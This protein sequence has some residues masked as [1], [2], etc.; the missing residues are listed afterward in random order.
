MR[1]RTLTRRF[2]LVLAGVTGIL[3]VL[4][5]ASLV[6]VR[7][8]DE[9]KLLENNA[10]MFAQ[11][12]NDQICQGYRVYY[13]SGSYKFLEIVRSTMELNQDVQRILV[14][15]VSGEVLYDSLESIDYNLELDRPVRR[16]EDRRLIEASAKL[17][18]RVFHASD[19]HL[20]PILM[21]V[22]PY[23]E[24]WG[25]HESSVL[26]VFNYRSLIH[27]MKALAL[28]FTGL[29]LGS[30]AVMALVARRLA[31]RIARPIEAAIVESSRDAVIG[32][33]LS[34]EITSWNKGAESIYGYSAGE[35]L[36]KKIDL[37]ISSE[38]AGTNPGTLEKLKR[39]EVLESYE[40]EGLRKD[41][42][43][44]VVSL[45]MSR[46]LGP[47]GKVIGASTIARDITDQKRAE[48]GQA[49]LY[50]IAEI[51]N[52]A[53]DLDSFYA[54]LHRVI[55]ELMYAQNFFIALSD[56][57]TGEIRFPYFVD[58]FDSPPPPLKPGQGLTGHIISTGRPLLL[59]EDEIGELDAGGKIVSRGAT[60]VDWLGVPLRTGDRTFGV[61]AV[62][63]Y[64]ERIRYGEREKDLLV[65]VSQH[66]AA[67]IEKKRAEKQI[68]R[69]AFQDALTGLANRIRLEDRLNVALASARRERHPLA[70][71]F[72][73]LDRFKVIN[74]SLGHRV[75]DLLLKEVA[76][77]LSGMVRESDTLSRLG[78]DEFLVLL[79]KLD[80]S[81]NA[82]S[83]ARKIQQ[84]F[85]KPFQVADREMFV[86]IS[87]GISIFPVDGEDADTL[88][89]HADAAMYAAKQRGRDNFQ[90]YSHDADPGGVDRLALETQLH[91]AIERSE[92]KVYFQPVVRLRD[93]EVI[94]AEALVRWQHP[95]R[96]LLLPDDFVSLAEDSGLILELGTFVLQEAC[97]ETVSWRNKWGRDLSVSV[98]LS[99]RQLQERGFV[100]NV[101]R[102]L[103]DTGLPA[104]A[105]S[106]EVT[107]SVA[108]QNLDVSLVMLRELR[109]LGI[110]ITMDDFGTGYS[111]LNYLKMLP[112]NTVKIDRSFI[113]D[114]ATDPN[115]AS[116]VRASIVMAHELRLRV[117]A[118]GVETAEQLRFLCENQCDDLQ[119]FLYSPA[120]T[121]E[122]LDLLLESNK[123]LPT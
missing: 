102:I 111:S 99:V 46:I 101:R 76:D 83:V 22:S 80:R 38:R 50:R 40:T 59:T 12:T 94:G 57:A 60:A 64:T 123:R 27:T 62:Q 17:H 117:V 7:Y 70:V 63:S 82:G 84:S 2:E 19:P 119:G 58:E 61:L 37:L 35:V 1:P 93:G 43:K 77:R 87:T 34:G 15:S 109:S 39:G 42:T 116:I 104:E 121:S 110:G 89:K 115:D 56:E 97:R 11:T 71:L 54:E 75:G 69:L 25:R 112:V 14:L 96:G 45:T 74:D 92:F 20:G 18:F 9:K 48:R 105:L 90:Y 88:V 24:E 108:M 5:A 120:I 118:E 106:L 47:G 98:N 86:T 122:E 33:S 8:R 78:G 114:V 49:A 100:A 66:I 107:E 6:F 67:A 26:Y 21:I 81:E 10:L 36:G 51:T 4:V 23:V 28:P 52:A 16:L 3:L 55:S 30:L 41:G 44:I 68:E 29:M 31:A 95:E 32:E 65:F 91:R 13:D 85:R 113:R 79:S 53:E 103:E 72:I 73:D